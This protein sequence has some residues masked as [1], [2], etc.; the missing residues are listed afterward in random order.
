[1]DSKIFV[2]HFIV[3]FE[4]V[5]DKVISNMLISIDFHVDPY[6][7]G[8]FGLELSVFGLDFFSLID[9]NGVWIFFIVKDL[10]VSFVK[11]FY[12]FDDDSTFD[13]QITV[14]FF[15]KIFEF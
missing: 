10:L 13:L 4:W 11:S 14:N 9:F 12:K 5:I 3:I 6:V 7:S 8:N 2:H 1:M 15:S